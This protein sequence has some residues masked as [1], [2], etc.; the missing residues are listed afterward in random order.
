MDIVENNGENIQH[1]R[2]NWILEKTL[3]IAEI[4]GENIGQNNGDNIGYCIEQWREQ[5]IL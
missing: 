1:W 2:E 5:W 4:N 3:D